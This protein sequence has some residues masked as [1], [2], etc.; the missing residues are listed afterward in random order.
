MFRSETSTPK[1]LSNEAMQISV[2][3]YLE[4]PKAKESRVYLRLRQKG[5]GKARAR[6]VRVGVVPNL[7]VN[8]KHWKHGGLTAAATHEQQAQVVAVQKRIATLQVDLN[9]R[10]RRVEASTVKAWIWP[11]E[12]D[13]WA[14]LFA[15]SEAIDVQSTKD[16]YGVALRRFRKHCQG[17]QPNGTLFAQWAKALTKTTLLP[18]STTAYVAG[19]RSLCDTIGITLPKRVDQKK[20]I[21]A[22]LYALTLGEIHAIALVPLEAGSKLAIVRDAFLCA[23]ASSLRLSDWHY[24]RVEHLGRQVINKKTKKKTLLPDTPTL[25]ELIKR[26]GGGHCIAS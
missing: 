12:T 22:K 1:P 20:K 19:V 17:H 25:H 10:P 21:E 14:R 2:H 8:P 26:N 13:Q 24:F 4:K 6:S 18:A 9:E 15:A 16:M 7:K 5:K 11:T 3:L 23:C